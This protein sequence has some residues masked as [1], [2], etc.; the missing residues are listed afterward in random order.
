MLG[1]WVWHV[2]MVWYAAAHAS[3]RAPPNL[4]WLGVW[5][6]SQGHGLVCKPHPLYCLMVVSA[7]YYRIYSRISRKIYDQI[8]INKWGGDLYAGHKK[9]CFRLV[10]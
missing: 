1:V 4:L 2:V 5:P 9:K 6:R 8:L 7:Y 10:T 3:R